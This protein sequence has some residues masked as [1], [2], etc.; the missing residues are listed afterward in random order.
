[1][2]WKPE[3]AAARRAKYRADPEERERRKAQG[4]T[5]EANREFMRD[6]YEANRERWAEYRRDPEKRAR[7]NQARRHRYANDPE[8]REKLK[9]LAR[10][11]D[12]DAK[13]D[14][15]LRRQFGIGAAEYDA[16]LAAQGGGCAI[17]GTPPTDTGP[18]LHVDHCHSGGNVRGILCSECNFGI[19]KFR[20]DPDLLRRAIKYLSR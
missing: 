7:R 2:A 6:Y 15:R 9:E 18:R 3:Y 16:M 8:Y 1:M 5:P 4:R 13:R 17:C 10:S 19:G 12:S 11:V 14:R 20:D